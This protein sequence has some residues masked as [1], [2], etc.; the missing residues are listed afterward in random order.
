MEDKIGVF[1]C[2]G[3]GI[4]EALDIDALSK[5]ATEEYKVPF[6]KTI[7][8]CEKAD[9][10]TINDDIVSE[11]L[12]KVVIAGISPRRYTDNMFPEDIIVEKVAIREHVV[13]CQPPN[14]ED[15]QMMA[16]DYLRMYITKIQKMETLEPFHPE[17]AIDKSI[18]VVGGGV[19]GLTS[20]LEAA[21]TGYDVRLVEKTDKLGGWLGKQYKS[22]PSKPPYRDLEDT[23]ID[24]LIAD[25]N[26][27]SRIKV[28]TSAVTSEITGAP[29]LFDVTL[30]S[31]GNGKPGGEVLDKFRVGA[32]IQATGWKPKEPRDTLSYGRVEDVIRNVDLEEMVKEQGRITRP[33]DGKEVKS[34]AFIQCGGSRNK[35]HHSH[36]SSIC[37]LTSLKQATYL[38]EQDENAKAYIFYEFIRTPGH[39]EDFY[40]KTQEDPGI[41]FTRGDVADVTR[42]EDGKLTVTAK[43][44]MQGEQIQVKVDLV[45]LAA[46]MVPNSADSEAIRALE[47]A[48]FTVATGESEVQKEKATEKVKE[49]ESHEGTQILNLEYRQGPDLPV[50]HYGFPDSHFICFPYESRRTGIYAAGSVRQP[51]DSILSREDATGAALK[52]IQCVEMT[53]RGEALHPRAGDKSYPDFFMQRCTQCKRCTEECPFGALN[54]DEKGTPLVHPTRCRR[55]GVCMGACPERIVTFK[56]FSVSIVVSMIQA[57]EVPDEYEEKP[58]ILAL[59][60][61]NDAFPAMDL[62]GQHRLHYDPF[63]RIIPVRCLGSVNT[64]WIKEAISSGYDGVI[65]IGCKYGDDYQCH[66][67]KGS[68]LAF[69]RGENIREKLEQMAMETERV[70]LHQLQI[71]EYEKLPEIFNNFAEVIEEYGMNPFKG[72]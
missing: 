48:K 30:K 62:V 72:M 37:C 22:I 43:D 56:D 3:Y 32:I 65:M 7:D 20:A 5:V 36:C 69:S 13:W 19:T 25:I 21:K 55:C 63:V 42:D 47:D 9:L 10:K 34:I 33:S 12:N 40:R 8:S 50:L 24:Q 66:F 16:E 68:E 2:T 59:L 15:T 17:E 39:Y 60:C 45:V 70:E 64:A 71:S 29:G 52:A 38:R 6:C 57:V 67:I 51:M 14:E 41:F 61:E 46:G 53:S 28:Y 58:R 54:E 44:T 35:D 23:R 4:A 49:L 26:G 11:G 18:L 31:N 1:I 27:N